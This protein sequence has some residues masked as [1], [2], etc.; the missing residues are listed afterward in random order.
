[1]QRKHISSKFSPDMPTKAQTPPPPLPLP[2]TVT[3]A[4]HSATPLPEPE[5]LEKALRETQRRLNALFDGTAN[6]LGLLAPDGTVLEMNRTALRFTGIAKADLV[7]KPLWKAGSW[8]QTPDT[9]AYLKDAITRAAV[10]QV[11]F[12]AAFPAEDGAVCTLD[13][14]LTPVRDENG[15]VLYLVPEGRDITEQR[16]TWDRLRASEARLAALISNFY[17]GILVED[18]NRRVVLINEAFCQFFGVPQSPEELI[19]ADGR[20]LVRQ[21]KRQFTDPVSFARRVEELIEGRRTVRGEEVTLADGRICERDYVPVF[22]DAAYLGHLWKYRDITERKRT[23]VALRASEERFRAISDAS[24]LGICVMDARLDCLY[25]NE[26]W[27][28]ITG[29]T[30]AE[31]A[32]QGWIQCIHPEDRDWALT[33]WQQAASEKRSFDGVYRY[34]HPDGK[35]VWGHVRAAAMYTQDGAFLGYVRVVEDITE[36]RAA[37]EALQESQRRLVEAQETAHIGSWE[38]DL[39]ADR[40]TWS[41]ETFRILGFDETAD[42]PDFETI[43]ERF[44][45]DDTPL[46]REAIY[47]ARKD[48]VPYKFDM[49]CIFPGAG[50]RWVNVM[51]CRLGPDESGGVLRLVGT[52][53]D[54][55]DRKHIEEDIAAKRRFVEEITRTTPDLLYIY[56]MDTRQ[57]VFIN[58]DVRLLP[59]RDS[60]EPLSGSRL[61]L[62]IHPDDR[63]KVAQARRN[64]PNLQDGQFIEFDCRMRGING[65]HRWMNSRETVFSRNTVGEPTEIFG[66]AHDI[67]TQREAEAVLRSEAKRQGRIAET[68]Q[69]ALLEL[70]ARDA[71]PGLD[72]H[73]VYRPAGNESRVGGDF[74]DAIPLRDGKVALVVGDVMGKGLDAATRM[75]EVK[76]SLRTLLREHPDPVIAMR[77]LNQHLYENTLVRQHPLVLSALTIGICDTVSGE[78]HLAVAA[79]EPPLI[80]YGN[81]KEAFS[82]LRGGPPLGALPDWYMDGESEPLFL[83]PQDTLLLYTDGITEGRCDDILFGPERVA[84][85]ASKRMRASGIPVDIARGLLADLDAFTHG[86]QHDDICLLLAR[87]KRIKPFA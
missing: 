73:T 64:Y 33:A 3:D 30:A 65:Q 44:H 86:Q 13:C 32:G 82:F 6:L 50:V 62:L 85:S 8:D 23:E 59:G 68:L 81:Q 46:L 76:Y 37:Q 84:A 2:P 87:R 57:E 34:R 4:P 69:Q 56:N 12:E 53:Q 18:E 60:D 25:V 19:G 14:S 29:L 67:T 9:P 42:A 16:R 52:I 27:Q 7:G 58:Q 80:L 63:D 71:F 39:T 48:G 17:G 38:Y 78:L 51:G 79:M 31:A 83:A 54:I 15:T 74:Y 40:T 75:A 55:T 22:V 41:R 77:R 49:R 24:P 61:S 10:E 72:L 26:V 36:R 43:L 66:I 11:Q 70:P 20:E 5:E 45:P 47:W 35:C 28:R 1:M 21:N